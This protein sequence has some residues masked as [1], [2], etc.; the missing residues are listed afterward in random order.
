M[1][2]IFRHAGR[3]N[4]NYRDV[5][6]GGHVRPLL[7]SNDPEVLGIVRAVAEGKAY[8]AIS[9][10]EPEIGSNVQGIHSKSKKVEGGYLLTGRELYNAR[11][12]QATH[13]VLF[14]QGTTGKPGWLSAFVVALDSPGIKSIELQAHGLVGNS[15]GGIEFTDLFVPESHRLG[16]DGEGLSIF[17]EHFRYW[18]LMQAAA[19]IGTGEQALEQMVDRLI[20]REAFGAPIGRFTHL[21]QQL[22]ESTIKLRMAWSLAKEAADLL[23]EKKPDEA[24]AL[25]SGLKAE[26]VEFALQATDWSMRAHGALGYSTKVDLG[27]RLNDLLGLRIADGTTDVMRMNAVRGMYTKHPIDATTGKPT[28]D[29]QGK[30]LWNLAIGTIGKEK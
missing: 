19:A 17:K 26:G 1:I 20:T 27:D 13:V 18:R 21:Q 29:S 30:T 24:Q 4:L 25:I 16:D 14:T 23:D 5:V 15:F 9:I 3:Y 11:L 28:K 22:G 2:E 10:T 12:T 7:K 8:I 6:G